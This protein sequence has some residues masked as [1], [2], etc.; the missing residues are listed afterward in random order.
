M[1]CVQDQNQSYVIQRGAWTK[2]QKIQIRIP[3]PCNSYF[4][5]IRENK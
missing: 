1:D 2:D 5:N 4:Y 3:N